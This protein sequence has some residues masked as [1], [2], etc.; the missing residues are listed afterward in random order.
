M[1]WRRLM[2]LGWKL[3]SAASS[4]WDSEGLYWRICNDEEKG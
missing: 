1:V 4:P 3:A 2:T